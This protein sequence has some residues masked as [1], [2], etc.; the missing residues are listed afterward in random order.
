[1]TTAPAQ[2]YTIDAT[3]KSIGRVA[4]DAAKKLMGKASAAYTPHLIPAAKVRIENAKKLRIAEK[5]RLQKTYTRYSG[6]PGGLK[7]ESLSHLI[8]RKGA[9]EALRHAIEGMLPRNT[10]FVQRMKNLTIH[11]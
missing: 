2:E 6:H 8:E 9:S 5:K 11:E 10:Q 7:E 3:G 1:M 4:A